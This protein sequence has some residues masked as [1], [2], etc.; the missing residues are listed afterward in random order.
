[1]SNLSKRQ[2][3]RK[4]NVALRAVYIL[5]DFWAALLSAVVLRH[6]VAKQRNVN[7]SIEISQ[8]TSRRRCFPHG[9]SSPLP[10]AL[11]LENGN[12]VLCFWS[13]FLSLFVIPHSPQIWIE[14]CNV[15]R[16]LFQEEDKKMRSYAVVAPMMLDSFERRHFFNNNNGLIEDP[17]SEYKEMYV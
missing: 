11:R 1:M 6:N 16:L 3:C 8:K 7:K 4:K 9:Y 5:S 12:A 17:M 10:T 15:L 14:P 13:H 2:S